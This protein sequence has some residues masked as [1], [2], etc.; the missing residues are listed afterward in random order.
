MTPFATSAQKRRGQKG[1]AY[2]NYMDEKFL[3]SAKMIRTFD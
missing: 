2:E 3:N 1:R